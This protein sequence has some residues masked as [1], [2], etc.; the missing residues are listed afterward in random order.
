MGGLVFLRDF[1]Q[2]IFVFIIN[3]EFIALFAPRAICFG[4]KRFLDDH[5]RQLLFAF[6][7]TFT[8]SFSLSFFSSLFF[9]PTI[10]V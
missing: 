1:Q 10:M 5:I 7:F 6:T 3:V 9:F 8:F 2:P 4:A